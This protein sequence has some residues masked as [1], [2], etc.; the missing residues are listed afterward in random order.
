MI[1]KNHKDKTVLFSKSFD[2]AHGYGYHVI[3]YWKRYS[4]ILS[5]FKD[6]VETSYGFSKNKFTA[7]RN[8]LSAKRD[9]F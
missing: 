6:I 8:A 9:R 1:T 4:N 5:E 7:Y 2:I 3:I